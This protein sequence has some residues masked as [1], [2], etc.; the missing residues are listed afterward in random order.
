MSFGTESVISD[1]LREELKCI[2]FEGYPTD[3][4]FVPLSCT[5]SVWRKLKFSA[6]VELQFRSLSDY[7]VENE[8]FS[9]LREHDLHCYPNLTRLELCDCE[10]EEGIDDEDFVSQQFGDLILEMIPPTISEVRL[11][12]DC[13]QILQLIVDRWELKREPD[14]GLRKLKIDE[15]IFCGKDEEETKK[16]KAALLALLD[17]SNGIYTLCS[18]ARRSEGCDRSIFYDA[19][20][21]HRLRINHA[22]QKCISAGQAPIKTALW[23]KILERAYQNSADIYDDTNCLEDVDS[24]KCATGTYYLLRH[25]PLL[26]SGNVFKK[27]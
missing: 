16:E 22:G 8:V 3:E 14:N 26:F 7:S 2:G 6:L 27:K 15:Q 5:S 11:D 9:D 19:E 25:G 12:R 17:T 18:E 4:I 23:P 20:V 10:L 24:L 1:E 13:I 21:E